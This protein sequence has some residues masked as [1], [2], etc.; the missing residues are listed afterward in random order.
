[1]TAASIGV[2]IG[3]RN[4]QRYI[5]E[6]IDSI[7]GQTLPPEQVVVVDDGSTDETVAAIR[8]HGVEPVLLP[9]QSGPAAARNA[10]AA[11]IETELIA[12][13]DGDDRMMPSHHAVLAAALGAANAVSGRTRQFFDPGREAE[14]AARHRLPHEPMHGGICGA[15]MFRRDAFEALGRFPVDDGVHD[16]FGLVQSLGEHPQVDDVVLERR[17]HG[18]NRSIVDRDGLQAE[19]LRAARQAI[20]DRRT[21]S[22]EGV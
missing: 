20:L 22:A 21:T 14:L 2:V 9:E 17:I 10:G 8:A 5:G 1:M 16:F 19:Y 12:F 6:A 18:E 4:Q 13:L 7:L 3:V 15:V 11:L